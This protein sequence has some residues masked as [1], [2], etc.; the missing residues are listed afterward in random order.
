MRACP[1]AWP[2]ARTTRSTIWL[3]RK[4]LRRTLGITEETSPEFELAKNRNGRIRR[5]TSLALSRLG[6]TCGIAGKANG[7]RI[8]SVQAGKKARWRRARAGFPKASCMPRWWAWRRRRQRLR[9]FCRDEQGCRASCTA[10]WWSRRRR[11]ARRR[12]RRASR[13]SCRRVSLR[14]QGERRRRQASEG[15]RA[16]RVGSR[17][18]AS[19]ADVMAPSM[20]LAWKFCSALSFACWA[21][22]SYSI[23]FMVG[24]WV[25]GN[26]TLALHRS[27]CWNPHNMGFKIG[28]LEKQQSPTLYSGQRVN[29]GQKVDTE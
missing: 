6:R 25:A 23:G 14:H 24:G 13:W 11:N 8:G 3:Q 17:D 27:S 19:R 2:Q 28:F 12:G 10:S 16:G 29:F 15:C 22:S 26:T 21:F 1:R 9:V 18:F 4:Q 5:S 20:S 7:N